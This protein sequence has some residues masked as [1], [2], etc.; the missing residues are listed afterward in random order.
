MYSAVLS[1][2]HTSDIMTQIIR[3]VDSTHIDYQTMG[4]ISTLD[5]LTLTLGIPLNITHW[6]NTYNSLQGY[7]NLSLLSDKN[8]VKNSCIP[9]L[10]RVTA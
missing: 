3:Q 7:Y 8:R 9:I 2:S 5:N 4:N 6:W 10:L 1:Y